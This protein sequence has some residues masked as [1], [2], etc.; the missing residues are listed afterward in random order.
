MAETLR[1][2]V[3]APLGDDA[4]RRIAERL[5]ATSPYPLPGRPV[6]P[7]N[8]HVTLRFLGSVDPVGRDRLLAG[9]DEAPLGGPFRVRW[10]ALGAFPRPAR[11]TVL[12]L[13]VDRGAGP[14]E[15][16]AGV[17]EEVTVAS[18]FAPE[19]R[20]FRSHLTLSRIRPHQDVTG[21]IERTGWLGIEMPVD[22]VVLYRSHLGR[23]GARYEEVEE[24]PLG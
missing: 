18:G 16:L 5:Q 15:A 6:R 19:D 4:R 8:W 1:L 9:L 11:A 10:G 24:F 23:G 7:E 3:A 14:L 13:G 22:R 12:W 2:F 20:P 21:L 17:V